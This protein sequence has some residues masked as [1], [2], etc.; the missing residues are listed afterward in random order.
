[1][2][3]GLP[4][5]VMGVINVS[6]ES[7]HAGSVHR[8]ADVLA[9]ALAMVEAGAS[10]I[11]VGARSTAPYLATEITPGEETARLVRAIERLAAKLPVPVSADTCRP[12]PARAALEA[13]ARVIN[14][15]SALSDPAVAR[16]VASH[17][18]SLILM[19]AAPVGERGRAGAGAR[20][21][22]RPRARSVDRLT[23]DLR[24]DAPA[25]VRRGT[26]RRTPR[27]PAPARPRSPAPV[28]IVRTILAEGMRRARGAGIPLRRI[29]VDPGIG[30]FRDCGMSWDQWD[31]RVLASLASLRSLGRPL[32]VGVSRKSFIGAILDRPDTADRLA[33]SLAA[34]AIAV[35][36]GAAVIRTHDV[37][38][39]RDAVRVAE[40]IRAVGG[41]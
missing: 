36:N 25:E 26:G 16:L 14:D 5:A 19:A 3:D 17:S 10:L 28:A 8:E 34:T 37:A 23:Q 20:G 32:C 6:P 29:V 39:T 33:G 4:V 38:E 40:R 27:A 21:V 15:V 30:F 9:T 11:D 31:C 13:G 12:E 22:R 2:G 7:F 35:M 24:S 41:R 1:M 18:A